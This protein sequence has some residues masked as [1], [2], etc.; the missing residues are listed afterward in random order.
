M[1][2]KKLCIVST[3]P[4]ALKVF[5]RE[6]I[7]RLSESLSIT[8]VCSGDTSEL[9]RIFSG[10]DVRSISINIERKIS[11]PSDLCSLAKL[12]QFF[13]KE[14]FDAVHSLMPKSGLLAMVAARL[15]GVPVRVH[16]YT[17][18]V[19]S[20]STGIKRI[21]LKSM[22]QLLAICA[23]RLMADSPSQRD[24]LV[25]EKVVSRD[26]ITVLGLGS[27]SGVDSSR[28]KPDGTA[29]IQIRAQL[30]IPDDAVVFL[31]MARV[32][33]A[34]GAVDMVQAF[35]HLSDSAPKAH[36]LMV[37]PDEEALES[38]LELLLTDI[39]PR[40]HRVGFTDS[41]EKFMAAADVFCLPSYREGFSLATIQAAG[42]GLPA[43]ASRIYGLT[44]AVDEG[45]TGLMHAPGDI[46]AISSCMLRL[47]QDKKYREQL[48]DTANQRAHST[49]SQDYIVGE[50]VKFYDDLLP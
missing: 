24:F 13:L 45:N 17:G 41:P 16:I 6:H 43:V 8:L 47:Y 18:Q 1:T 40:Y 37:G 11:F 44:D 31:F 9:E 30:N 27:I 49:F 33:Q 34:K 50:M 25:A 19:W 42:A 14:N 3:V 38:Q 2:K 10:V 32:T 39:K 21:I 36:L 48:A 7:M 22:D 26:K 20:T 46:Q 35:R 4:V 29:R 15:V 12:R 23:T 28:F 5:M